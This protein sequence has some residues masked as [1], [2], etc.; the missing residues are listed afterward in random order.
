V[1]VGV[2]TFSKYRIVLFIGP[3]RIEQTMG[4]IK[5]LFAINGYLHQYK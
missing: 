3:G 1:V 2:A 4:S 5:M